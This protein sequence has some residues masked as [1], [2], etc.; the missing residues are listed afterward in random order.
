METPLLKRLGERQTP[1]SDSGLATFSG[2]EIH[3]TARHYGRNGMLVNH[4]SDRIAKQHDILVK[5]FN[6]SLQLDT[7]DKVNGDRH[8]LAAQGVEE[9]VLQ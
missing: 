1:S 7:V 9:W 8:V 5:R 3:G 4:L 6:L 2:R